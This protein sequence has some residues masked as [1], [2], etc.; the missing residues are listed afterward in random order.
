MNHREILKNSNNSNS[1]WLKGLKVLDLTN[2]IAGPTIGSTL[3]RFGAHVTSVQ[4]VEPSVDPWN[5]VVFGVQ[6]QRGK[7]SILLN[8]KTS[9]GQEILS[10]LIAETDIITM[11]GTDQQRESLGLSEQRIQDINSNA[12]LVQLDAL[13]GPSI[14]PKSNYLGYDD[15]AQAATGVMVRFGGSLN[16]PE[17]HAHFG[18]IDVLTGYCACIA[19]GAAMYQ[20][21]QTGKTGIARTSLSAAGNM[22]QAY[23][24][25]DFE[26]R[27]PFDEPSG[28]SALGWGPFYH[29]YQTKDQWVFF[30]SPTEGKT[31][32]SHLPEF[33]DIDTINEDTLI[34]EL[35]KRFSKLS[36]K[37]LS[38]AFEG[39]SSAMIPL[40]SLHKTRDDALTLESEGN[41]DLEQSTFC[42]I[43]HDS[44]PM[45]RWVDL[46]APNA[47][48]SKKSK[49]Q[50]PSP[51][52]KYGADT[53]EI[54]K[55]LGYNSQQIDEM[56]SAKIVGLKWGDNYLPE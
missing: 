53:K 55:N 41:I 32:L 31:R 30:A 13:G 26:N 45:G 11:N 34:D 28:R 5:T 23:F 46:V 33:A 35:S 8:L 48:R 4:P 6:A 7:K 16:T 56:I 24:M 43:R 20:S 44:H 36:Y 50:I 12:I 38:S 22:I 15:L 14:G 10:K 3:A 40:G 1:G 37:Y 29:C 21:K 25:Y 52:P 54:L 19:L 18:T 51:A 42:V 27:P 49:I 39:T 9:K 2:V 17:E 47:V